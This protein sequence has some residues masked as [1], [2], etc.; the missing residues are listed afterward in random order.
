MKANS[1]FASGFAAVLALALAATPP[2]L[3]A[4]NPTISK[5][6]ARNTA[7]QTNPRFGEAVAVNEKWIVVGEPENDDFGTNSGAVHIFN[8][9]TRAWVRKLTAKS[10]ATVPDAHPGDKFGFS[11]AVSGDLALIGAARGDTAVLNDDTGCAYVFNLVTGAFVRKLAA[12]DGEQNEQF[13]GSVAL[14]GNLALVGAQFGDQDS[15]AVNDCGAAYLFKANTGAQV[16]K[17]TAGGAEAHANDGFGFSVA[18]NG[19]LALVG[20]PS[21]DGAEANTGTAYLFDAAASGPTSVPTL[22]LQSFPADANDAFGAS[23]ALSGNLALVG[24]SGSGGTGAAFLFS[25]T[26]STHVR[27]PATFTTISDFIGKSVALSGGV[28]I[29][30]ASGD[31]F[32]ANAT[33]SAHLFDVTNVFQTQHLKKLTPPDSEADDSFGYSAALSGNVAVI[34][35]PFD[36]DL[37]AGTGSVYVLQMP[38]RPF[39]LTKVA[40]LKDFAPRAPGTSFFSFGDAFIN[41]GPGPQAVFSATLAGAGATLGRNAGVWDTIAANQSFDLALRSGVDLNP[42]VPAIPSGVKATGF[43]NLIANQHD[44]AVFIATLAGTGVTTGNNRA[45]FGDD[46][47]TSSPIK[48]LRLGDSPMGAGLRVSKFLQ[49]VQSFPN[50]GIPPLA[51][52]FQLQ[53]S[54]TPVSVTA[55]ND[56]GIMA[57]TNAGVAWDFVRESTSPVPALSDS[58]RFGQFSRVSFPDDQ[59]VFTAA[60]HGGTPAVTAANNQGIFRWVPVGAVTLIKRKSDLAPDATGANLGVGVVFSAFL[61]ETASYDSNKVVFRASLSGP[62]VTAANNEGLWSEHTGSVKLVAR[63]GGLVPLPVPVAGVVWSQF[64]NYW[65]MDIFGA[66]QVLFL[67][68]MRGPGVTTLNDEALCLLEE[69]GNFRLLLRKGDIAPDCGSATIGAIQRVVA[70]ASNGNYAVLA[71]LA[72]SSAA[73]NQALFTGATQVALAPMRRPFLKLRKGTLYQSPLGTTT[74]L[75]SLSL[76]ASSFDATGAGAKGLGQ[77]MNANGQMILKVTFND[78]TVELMKGTP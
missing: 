28:A 73:T 63:E 53:L 8:A 31:D 3:Q 5:L 11:V 41:H 72:N 33:G 70:D 56:T 37:G 15:P 47:T 7:P 36:D 1:R 69:N 29:V 25:L 42:L 21:G 30:G 45:I 12:T 6:H 40:A 20:A 61:G 68:R 19:H 26:Q 46:G 17:L 60:L 18:L 16:S 22:N 24:A 43:F 71:S 77:S 65:G 55:T 74:T 39:P 54:T 50:F 10:S 2:P 13:G 14:S 62:G 51:V 9:V 59:M 34:G 52:A 35:A 32:G 27:L 66:G 4:F 67:A 78:L 49:M 44:M 38:A 48:L 58:A 76:P 57:L 75:K 64:R 23:V